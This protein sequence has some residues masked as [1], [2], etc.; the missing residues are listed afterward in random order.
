MH[1]PITKCKQFTGC[2]K[3]SEGQLTNWHKVA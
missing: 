2:G 1:I 3:D